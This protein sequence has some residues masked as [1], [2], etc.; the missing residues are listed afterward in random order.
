MTERK[1][2]HF[3]EG[4]ILLIN[5]P[6]GWT[7]F[8]VVNHLRNFIRRITG[9]RKIKVGHAGTLDPLASGLLLICTGKFTKK[10]NQFMDLDKEYTG[11]IILGATTPSY[12]RETEIDQKYETSHISEE[13]LKSRVATFIGTQQQTPPAFSAIKY[14]GKPAYIYARK[15]QDVDLKK[16]TITIYDFKITRFDLPEINFIISCSKGTYIRSVARDLGMSLGSG[17]YL[18]SLCRTRI[19]DFSLNQSLDIEQFKESVKGSTE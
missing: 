9:D 4:E 10:I 3:T 17:G 8:D 18:S 16:R 19:G 2:Y 11:T 14:K 12:D 7:S 5:K 1:E 6:V 15:N 13:L